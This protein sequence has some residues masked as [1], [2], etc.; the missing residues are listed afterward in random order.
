MF[1]II[2][3][4]DGPLSAYWL[5]LLSSRLFLTPPRPSASFP[6]RHLSHDFHCAY[7]NFHQMLR[8]SLRKL[9]TF[10]A[11]SSAMR[12]VM[13]IVSV[14]AREVKVTADQLR[15]RHSI[16]RLLLNIFANAWSIRLCCSPY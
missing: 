5:L 16:S 12:T 7:Y 8:T 4:P 9:A 10:G 15:V 1:V 6:S 2:I 14:P 13:P 11:S 3:L